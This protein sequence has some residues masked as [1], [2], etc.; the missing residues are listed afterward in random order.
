MDSSSFFLRNTVVSKYGVMTINAA[1]KMLF[2]APG[3][4]I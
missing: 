1:V 3:F 2:K 4:Q